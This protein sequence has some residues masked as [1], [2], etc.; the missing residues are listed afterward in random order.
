MAEALTIARPYAEAAF[1]LAS[2]AKS[3]PQWS[4]ALARLAQV[5]VSGPAREV[6]GNPRLSDDQVATVFADVAG[7]LDAEQRKFLRV[8]AANE[9]LAVLPEIAE[10]FEAQ[11][12]A[13]EGV[14]DA[15]ITSAYPMFEAQVTEVVSSLEKK[16][17]RKVKA[18][19]TV[20]ADLIGGVSIR[21]G[22]EVIDASV[23]G[24]LTQLA[25][26]LVK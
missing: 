17:G 16:Y 22:D 13:A 11:K 6:I 2:D 4:T 19:V 26:A 14:L 20:D 23:R 15:R 8:L 24:K 12:N 10:I 7:N 9:R 1:K 3:L 18:T 25:D 5:A 21:I